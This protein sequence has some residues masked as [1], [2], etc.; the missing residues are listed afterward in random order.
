VWAVILLLACAGEGTETGADT[1]VW[2]QETGVMISAP[3]LPPELA[4]EDVEPVVEQ[5]MAEEFFLPFEV[6][7]W[8]MDVFDDLALGTGTCPSEEATKGEEGRWASFWSGDCTGSR[9]TAMGNWLLDVTEGSDGDL[10]YLNAVELWSFQ[11]TVLAD[12]GTVSGGGQAVVIWQQ[13]GSD[14][15]ILMNTLGTFEDTSGP[16][17]LQDGIAP[18]ISLEGTWNV[19]S[20]YA[21]TLSGPVGAGE[22]ALDFEELT[23]TGDC[24]APTGT[25]RVRDPSS[26]WWEIVLPD[27]CTGCGSLSYNGEEMG[28]A[29]PGAGVRGVLES[30]ITNYYGSHL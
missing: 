11:G 7:N 27:D 14:A 30:R 18:G 17:P 13:Q 1:Q 2:P 19:K 9:Y 22:L 20:G 25:L 8:F 23:F 24:G 12:S 15:V 5:L 16:L 6:H 28:E 3:D 29:C 26:A 4:A 10:Y 21:G